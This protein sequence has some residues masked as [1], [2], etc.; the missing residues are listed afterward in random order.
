[1]N[2]II[3]CKREGLW[4]SYHSNGQLYS[5]GNYIN[6]KLDGLWKYYDKQG[7]IIKKEFF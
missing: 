3:N 4:K 5:E 1:M 7:K 2:K 6:D